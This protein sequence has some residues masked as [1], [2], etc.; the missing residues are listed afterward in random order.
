[1][2]TS[3]TSEKFQLKNSLLMNLFHMLHQ[4]ELLCSFGIGHVCVLRRLKRRFLSAVAAVST[5]PR[6][7]LLFLA[8]SHILV[9]I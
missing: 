9:F 4:H 7:V 6:A 3:L 8:L 2:G 5:G 1:M